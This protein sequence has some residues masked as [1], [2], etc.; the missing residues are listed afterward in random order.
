MYPQTGHIAADGGTAHSYPARAGSP[1][2]GRPFDSFE[3][4]IFSANAGP[5][6][7]QNLGFWTFPCP[8]PPCTYRRLLGR[9]ALVTCA[10][11]GLEVRRIV[12]A[13]L[14]QRHNVVDFL[15]CGHSPGSLAHSA[16]RIGSQP[17]CADLRPRSA[18]RALSC[19][20][21]V[22]I[23]HPHPRRVLGGDAGLQRLQTS[24]HYVDLQMKQP[25]RG[26][27]WGCVRRN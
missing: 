18:A 3:C 22:H 20:R 16:Q 12:G 9:L 6:G 14:P 8:L 15:G 10:A 19:A 24:G 26:G 4:G 1:A 21:A 5:W 7:Y 27:L 13:A 2:H 17:A 11:K 25:A 23:E